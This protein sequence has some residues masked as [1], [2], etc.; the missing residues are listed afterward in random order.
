MAEQSASGSV[1]VS[2]LTTA[3][4]SQ[5][6]RKIAKWLGGFLIVFGVLGYFAA[7][8]LIK[9][10]LQKQLSQQLHRDVTVDQVVINPY[11]LSARV[12]GLSIKAEGGKE[13][14]GFDELFVNLSSASLFKF[15]AVVDEIR[16]RG[17]RIAV[18]RVADG[19]YDISDL[20]DEWMKPKDE[21]DT[22]TPRFSLNNIQLIDGKIVFDDQPKGKIHTISDIN[23]ALPFVSSLP[24]Q[25]EVLV[26]PSFSANINGSMLALEGDSKP[27]SESHESRL[28][29][30]L[31]RYVT[32]KAL[33]GLFTMLGEEEKKI[34]T[35]PAARTTELLKT[36]FGS[37]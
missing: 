8:P 28:N 5:R 2:R 16:L 22:G 25:A 7:P 27:F 33:D 32:D 4:K 26:K 17:L 31:D 24:Y 35:N 6:S 3:V 18:A 12:D 14:A 29:L 34:R 20:L 10:V 1:T 23:L 30:D 36:V 37:K 21:P 11:G 15:A 19:R 13:V 9:S